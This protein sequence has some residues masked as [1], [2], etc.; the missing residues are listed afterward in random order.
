MS[1]PI[2]RLS[3]WQRPVFLLNSRLGLL[4]AA[5][6][7]QRGSRP[8]PTVAP[9]I[10]KLR[11][12]LAEFLNEGSLVHLRVLTPT[13]QCRFA[14]RALATSNEAF[15]DSLGSV[16]SHRVS[17][18]LPPLLSYPGGFPSPE[19]PGFGDA[20]CPMGTPHLPSCV[21]PLLYTE[22]SGA[23]ILTSCPSPTPFGL[24]LGPTNPT[25]IDLP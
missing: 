4:T 17:P 1:A 23:G 24:G 12:Q 5:T 11:G 18:Q 14:V 7:G 3:P 20:P 10:P 22:A 8:L 6:T 21:P 16:E 9:L 25:R 19:T 2:L 15:L 13:Y